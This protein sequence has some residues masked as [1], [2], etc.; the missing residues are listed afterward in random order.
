[1]EDWFLSL[2]EDEKVRLLRSSLEENNFNI[3]LQ[4]AKILL[5]APIQDGGMSTEKIEKIRCEFF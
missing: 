2:P 4:L 3:F 1:M 5:D